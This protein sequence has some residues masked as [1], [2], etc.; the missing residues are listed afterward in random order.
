MEDSG[1]LTCR[2]LVQ[3]TH[4]SNLQIFERELFR[5]ANNET[6]LS[7]EASLKVVVDEE[8]EV[9]Y[10]EEVVEEYEADYEQEGE[11]KELFSYEEEEEVE[12]DWRSRAGDLASE[13]DEN[14]DD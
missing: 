6:R 1:N 10:E 13:K 4:L 12:W 2:H 5:A 11:Y 7:F 3:F 8:E 9:E 14:W